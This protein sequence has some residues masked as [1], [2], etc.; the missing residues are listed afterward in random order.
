MVTCT[1]RAYNHYFVREG[2]NIWKTLMDVRLFV[3][4]RP[5]LDFTG[6]KISEKSA[7]LIQRKRV[8]SAEHNTNNIGKNRSIGVRR[9]LRRIG[10]IIAAKL[11]E[12]IRQT[13][14]AIKHEIEV[15]KQDIES[16]NPYL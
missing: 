10:I 9:L 16:P 2:K 8:T 13:K 11:E 15:G 12:T 1:S 6:R 5:I 3:S 14:H 4:L 7:P